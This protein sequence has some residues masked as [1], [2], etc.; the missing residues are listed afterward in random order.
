M[1]AIEQPG[2]QETVV[3]AKVFPSITLALLVLS[4]AC[5][6]L[7]KAFP[8]EVSRWLYATDFE[9]WHGEKL[10]SLFT[11]LFLH[12]DFLHLAFNCYWVWRLGRVLEQEVSRP[13]Y[14]ALILVTTLFGSLAEFAVSAQTG[15]GMSGMLYGLFGYML[16]ERGR[17]PVFRRVLD[18]N[19]IALLLGW[20]VLCF[21]LTHRR[22]MPVANF[23]HV[24]GLVAGMLCGFAA[25]GRK[26]R[27]VALA[28]LCG[29]L[30]GCV[31][32]LFW[33]PWHDNWHYVQALDALKMHIKRSFQ[34]PGFSG[35]LSPAPAAARMDGPGG[36]GSQNPAEGL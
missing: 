22:S 14:A 18:S 26:F 17:R 27:K 36:G 6:W 21:W 32:P 25:S 23:A 1:E 24:G 33:A 28:G 12:V 2:S 15:A 35:V 8:G 34:G 3:Q 13:Q 19:T 5:T 4:V 16:V 30:L 20:L 31:A 10:W 7:W 29:M 11:S 9:F